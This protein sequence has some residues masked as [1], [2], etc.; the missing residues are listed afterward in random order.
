[1]SFNYNDSAHKQ[2]KQ[3]DAYQRRALI[4]LN[5][6]VACHRPDGRGYE[7]VFPALAGNPIVQAPDPM[8]LIAIVMEGYTTPRTRSTPAQFTMPGFAW[9]C[10]DNDV[11]DLVTYIRRSWGNSAQQVD[12]A[13]LRPHRSMRSQD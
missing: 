11:A 10:S 13:Q 3:G 2:V 1:V 9:R 7:G 5:N 12:V 4:Y 6:C 8:S